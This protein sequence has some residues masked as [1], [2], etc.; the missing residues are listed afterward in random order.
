MVI[1]EMTCR[2]CGLI[3]VPKLGWKEAGDFSHR[4]PMC[5]LR[6]V[7]YSSPYLPSESPQIFSRLSA[8]FPHFFAQNEVGLPVGAYCA[9]CGAWIKW[10]KQTEEIIEWMN[11]KV[12]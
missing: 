1:K 8:R 11:G 9:G 7:W 10:V 2:R 4:A 6:I 12:S 5:A 3:E